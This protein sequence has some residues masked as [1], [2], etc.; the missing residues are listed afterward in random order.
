MCLVC[1]R[2]CARVHVCMRVCTYGVGCTRVHIRKGDCVHGCFS[3]V[4]W[5]VEGA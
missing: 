3:W 4:A 1:V 2:V 5:W